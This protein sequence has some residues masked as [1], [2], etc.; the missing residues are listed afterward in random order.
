MRKITTKY[1]TECKTAK[2]LKGVGQD[3]FRDISDDYN[4]DL[5]ESILYSGEDTQNRGGLRVDSRV[6][7]VTEA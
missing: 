3:Y 7:C 4:V 5:V 1:T 6:W 2:D